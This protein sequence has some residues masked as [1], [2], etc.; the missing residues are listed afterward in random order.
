[1][2]IFAIVVGDGSTI[3]QYFKQW[4]FKGGIIT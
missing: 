1:M 3:K 2:M 4:I